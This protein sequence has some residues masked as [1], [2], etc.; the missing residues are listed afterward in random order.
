MR[1]LI[2]VTHLLGTGHLARALTLARAFAAAG[3]E[4]RVAS[5]GFPAP[6]LDAAGLRV[7]Q[8]PPLR[9][10]G[11]DFARL[12]DE[13]GAPA[14]SA[15]LAERA[16]RLSR[17]MD[18]FAPHALITELFPFGRRALSSEFQA[19]LDAAHRRVPRPAVL[20]SIRDILAPPST[21]EKAARTAALVAGRYD[22][23]LVHSD[24][25][26]VP[27]EASW[28][29]TPDLAARLAYTGFVAPPAAA[30]HPEGLGRGEILVS[31]GG[32]AV[33]APLFAAA[34]GAARLVP[35]RRWRLLTGGGP[36][37]AAALA[38]GGLP[39]NVTA[40]PARP[41]FRAMLYH[42]ACSVSLCGYNTALDVLQAAAPAVF[43]PFDEGGETEQTLRAERLAE[44]PGIE[45]LRA[46]ALDPE[47]LAAAVTRAAAAPRR[48]PGGLNFDG[49]AETVR[50]ARAIAKERA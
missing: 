35:D 44:R 43:V 7:D 2:V 22:R 15:L 9:S 38:A 1:V 4:V 34:I 40:E 28:P 42:A 47:E 20:A 29:V 46:G 23:V 21:P 24:P 13:D 25:R 36:E 18:S 5:G 48:A 10:D 37:R 3:D 49:A 45:L 17:L 30:A 31:A 41:D 33:G 14:S 19:L 27:L 32:G 11:T 39:A 16:A 6:H 8:L 12:L 50:L 26:A